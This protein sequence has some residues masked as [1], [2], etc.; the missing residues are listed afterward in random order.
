MFKLIQNEW[1]KIFKRPG[2][3]VM[4]GLIV[5]II[6]IMGA[7]T[8]YNDLHSASQ[9]GDWKQ[10]LTV[11]NEQTKKNMENGHMPAAAKDQ[12]KK[13]IAINDYRIQ[14]DIAPA[15]GETVW[16]FIAGASD[17]ISFIGLFT[18]IVAASIVASEFNW[19]TIKLLL[20]R[21]I[22]RWRILLSKYI[23]TILFGLSLLF[24]L[25]VVT[26]L[27][28]LILFGTGE[29]SHAYLAYASGKVV[30]Q[31]MLLHLVK[32]YLFG[33]IDLL[34]LATMA[35]M[36]SAVFRNSSLAIGIS[37]FLLFSGSI[38]TTLVASKFDWAK[39][40]LF[41]NTDLTVYSDGVPLVKGMTLGFSVTVLIIYFIVFLAL[42]F[43]VF[44]K[45]D[46]AA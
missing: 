11:Q 30:E 33:S 5:L 31:S 10:A 15:K 43:G 25:F 4:I 24:I 27:L 12:L 28:G 39:Y 13:Q 14:H 40:I 16:T 20:I 23:T 37:I 1:I 44:S 18:I 35:F 46:V 36:I 21:P 3:Y 9:K 32:T 8:K 29:G 22:S 26:G 19:G 42:A 6:G 17:L 7:F 38:F 45:R 41:A 34:M 2:T